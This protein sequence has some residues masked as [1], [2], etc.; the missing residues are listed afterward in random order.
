MRT[1]VVTQAVAFEWGKSYLVHALDLLKTPLQADL[2]DQS[3]SGVF[4]PSR[5]ST[6]REDAQAAHVLSCRARTPLCLE[7]S[8]YAPHLWE[9]SAVHMP[10]CIW[11]KSA[12]APTHKGEKC[13]CITHL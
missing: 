6:R 11:E 13:M 8:A 2:I 9:K 4:F 5:P 3:V 1:L 7:G 12:R 10:P